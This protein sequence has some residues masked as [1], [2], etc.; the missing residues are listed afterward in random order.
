MNV[1]A[2]GCMYYKNCGYMQ[3]FAGKPNPSPDASPYSLFC[4]FCSL[5]PLYMD[6]VICISSCVCFHNSVR[7]SG[8]FHILLP[9]R[10]HLVNGINLQKY[11]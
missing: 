7:K 3:Y 9:E 8:P 1:G 5:E 4:L 10:L 6:S 2:F 11:L